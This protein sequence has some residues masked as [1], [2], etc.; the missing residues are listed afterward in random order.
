MAQL[1]TILYI[2]LKICIAQLLPLLSMHYTKPCKY[3]HTTCTSTTL[4]ETESQE[5]EKIILKKT[6]H[7]FS[8]KISVSLRETLMYIQNP[9]RYSIQA[10]K[11]TSSSIDGKAYG[12]D[13]I[14]GGSWKSIIIIILL[15]TG[16]G[17]GPFPPV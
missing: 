9:Y 16:T 1:C 12:M 7:I 15:A 3:V 17:T 8:L 4:T 5:S 2:S 13:E 6:F 14:S 10:N 11:D